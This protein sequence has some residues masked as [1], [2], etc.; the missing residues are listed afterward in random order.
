MHDFLRAMLSSRVVWH[1]AH[2]ICFFN[3]MRFLLLIK[4]LLNS[5]FVISGTIKVEVSVNITKTSF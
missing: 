5:I 4:Q 3:I 2:A 1:R